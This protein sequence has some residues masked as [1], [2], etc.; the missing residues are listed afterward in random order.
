MTDPIIIMSAIYYIAIS[1]FCKCFSPLISKLYAESIG[2]VRPV[3][4]ET[5]P[6]P[7]K[8]FVRTRTVRLG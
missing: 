2:R 3:V 7:R 4:F 1:L 5:V 6:K 8:S